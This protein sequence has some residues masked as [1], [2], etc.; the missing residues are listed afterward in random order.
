MTG[1]A[2]IASQPHNLPPLAAEAGA[3][4]EYPKQPN[5][6]LF[7]QGGISFYDFKGYTGHADAAPAP[8]PPVVTRAEP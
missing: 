2:R 5:L 8:T 4:I 6:H 7:D 3:A 1:R